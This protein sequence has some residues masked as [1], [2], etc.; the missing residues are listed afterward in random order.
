MWRSYG[1]GAGAWIKI[2]LRYQYDV[3]MLAIQ[4]CDDANFDTLSLDF[5]GGVFFDVSMHNNSKKNK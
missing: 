4:Q 5:E 1:E 3:S 2:T